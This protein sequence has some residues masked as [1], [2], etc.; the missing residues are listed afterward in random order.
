M[1]T[2]MG[3]RNWITV[4]GL[5]ATV[6]VVASAASATPPW[7]KLIPF[8]SVEADSSKS[9]WLT[10][11]HG[12]WLIF[13]TSFAGEGAEQQAHELVYELRKKYKME[14][15]IHKRHFDFD[16]PV[17]GRGM[18]RYGGPRRM[19]YMNAASFDEYAVLVGNYATHDAPPA[20][21]MLEKVKTAKP[22]CLNLGP[23]LDKSAQRFTVLRELQRMVNPDKRKMGPMRRAFIARNPLLPKEFFVGSGLDPFVANMNKGVEHS[24]LDCPGNYTVRVASFR[25]KSYFVGEGEGEDEKDRKLLGALPGFGEPSGLELAAI[26]AHKLTE[27]LRARGVEAYEFHDRCE[28]IVTVGSF[29][30]VGNRLPDGRIDLHPEIHRIMETYGAE[31]SPLPGQAQGV[32]P[33]MLLKDIPFDVQPLPVQVPRRSIASDYA[34]N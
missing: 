8:K 10:E 25:G 3:R 29:D 20:E 2:R 26:N 31:R 32:R 1:R 24:L 19:R 34:G 16:K 27:A 28:S 21:E 30:T 15:Y 7:K 5:L 14:A 6:L 17:Y 23:E 12:P 18:N 9:Y 33:R 22:E 11:D 13:A 4:A